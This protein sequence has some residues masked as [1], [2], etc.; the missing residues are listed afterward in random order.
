MSDIS[1]QSPDSGKKKTAGRSTTSK[2]K[3]AERVAAELRREIV[4]GKL[5]P[6]DRLHNER[7]LQ[8]QF[9]I[10]RPTLR[11][12]LRMLEAE[13]LIVITRGQ[14]GGARVTRQDPAVLARG[15]GAYLQMQGVTLKDVWDARTGIEPRAARMLAENASAEAMEEMQAN[16]DAA[17]GAID[18]PVAYGTLTNEFSL[19]ITR[20]CGNL[21]LHVLASLIQ[22]IVSRQHVDVTVRTYSKAGVERMREL[23]I[24]GRERLLDLVSEGN[25]EEAEQHWRAH[26]EQSGK[27]VFSAYQARMP[28]DMVQ[29]P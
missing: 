9:G 3:I 25:G 19:I 5:R 13:S 28:I 14:Y 6:G 24:R 22:D 18:D 21:T 7:E 26:I 1:S 29:L 4:T 15:V 27:V 20:H 2:L 16:I 23:N 11:E 8:E 12:A 17:R 10:S